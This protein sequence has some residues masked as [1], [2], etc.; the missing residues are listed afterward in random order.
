MT[1]KHT[2]RLL[3]HFATGLAL[4]VAIGWVLVRTG[5]LS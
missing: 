2:S 5:A 1:A 4:V 3:T